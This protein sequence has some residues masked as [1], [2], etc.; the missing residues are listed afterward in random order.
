MG[1]VKSSSAQSDIESSGLH[2]MRAAKLS[3]LDHIDGLRV[4]FEQQTDPLFR[5]NFAWVKPNFKSKNIA[6]SS[7]SIFLTSGGRYFQIRGWVDTLVC[8]S[9]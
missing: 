3:A 2:F 5:V 7:S 6:N 9:F 8:A 1:I 4:V